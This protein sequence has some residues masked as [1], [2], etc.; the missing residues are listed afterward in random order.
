MTSRPFRER[1]REGVWKIDRN[2]REMLCLFAIGFGVV[3]CGVEGRL[4]AELSRHGPGAVDRE[5][6]VGVLWSEAAQGKS[7]IL[8]VTLTSIDILYLTPEKS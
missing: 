6:R 4:G 3:L 7:S 2:V 5:A 1:E 8:M